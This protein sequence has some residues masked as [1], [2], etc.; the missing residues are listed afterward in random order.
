MQKRQ[1]GRQL[2]IVGL[3]VIVLVLGAGFFLSNRGGGNKRA[4]ASATTL[5]EVVAVE[6]VPQGTV[7]TSGQTLSA[8]FTVRQAPKSLVPF[9]AYSSVGQI[10][11]LMQSP[12]CGPVKAAGC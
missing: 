5:S 6:P 9:G 7:F 8:Y 2:I 12:G 10:S 1:N 4:S 11:G 3:V